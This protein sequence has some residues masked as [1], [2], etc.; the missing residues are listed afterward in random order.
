MKYT[1]EQID[2]YLRG[3]MSTTEKEAFEAELEHDS[4]LAREVNMMHLIVD[5]LKNRQDKL[6]AISAWRE[7]ARRKAVAKVVVQHPWVPWVTAFSAAAALVA[8]VFLFSPISSPVL[9]PDVENNH[10]IIRGTG[11]PDMDSLIEQGDFQKAIEV[12]DAEIAENDSLLRESIRVRDEAIYSVKKYEYA[13]Q[14]LEE[15]KNELLTKQRT[16]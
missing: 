1:E 15:K 9:P 13:I 4:A 3:E 10:S 14:L 2:A 5:G 8:G 16:E 7:E 12:I 6:D 11:L